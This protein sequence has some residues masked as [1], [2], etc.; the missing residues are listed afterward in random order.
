MKPASVQLVQMTWLCDSPLFQNHD[1][2]TPVNWDKVWETVYNIDEM[3]F[4]TNHLVLI[5]VLEF[6]SGV[7]HVEI[8][9]DEIAELPT[10][11]RLAVVDA[12]RTHWSDVALQENL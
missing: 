5:S 10:L 1:E 3:L 12:L 2:V 9:L 6:L 4:N 8:A 11:E 7:D